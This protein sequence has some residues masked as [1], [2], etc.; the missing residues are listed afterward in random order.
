MQRLNHI[1]L[2]WITIIELEQFREKNMTKFDFPHDSTLINVWNLI[3]KSP[4]KSFDCSWHATQTHM[5]N[6]VLY[7]AT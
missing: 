6:A 3:P 2:A 5:Q 7:Y 4:Y 1:K